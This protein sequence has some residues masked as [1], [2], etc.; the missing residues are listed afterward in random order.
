MVVAAC[1]SLNADFHGLGIA[2]LT[3]GR[4]IL[5]WSESTESKGHAV[6][7]LR[8]DIAEAARRIGISRTIE[9]F[10]FG[11][12]NLF[13]V[14]N[15]AG[16]LIWVEVEIAFKL[17]KI[18]E[19]YIDRDSFL[20]LRQYKADTLPGESRFAYNSRRQAVLETDLLVAVA[21]ADHRL[22]EMVDLFDSLGLCKKGGGQ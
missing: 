16:L 5:H 22:A 4:H 15:R 18:K 9:S 2:D 10:I 1:G 17:Y 11:K 3:C 12:R 19:F 6:Q 14:G 7:V 20:P 13:F 21:F 8:I